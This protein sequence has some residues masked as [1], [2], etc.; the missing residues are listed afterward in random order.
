MMN[1]KGLHSK[2]SGVRTEIVRV[3]EQ[4]AKVVYIKVMDASL[5]MSA[6][7]DGGGLR[8]FQLAWLVVTRIAYGNLNV[9]R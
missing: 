4:N 9:H 1:I 2:R 3:V 7:T 5:T 6:H 8:M